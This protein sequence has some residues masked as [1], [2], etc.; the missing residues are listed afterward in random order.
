MKLSTLCYVK[1]DD[2]TLMMNRNRKGD[3][4]EGKW[5]GLGGKF[6]PGESPEECVIREVYEESGLKIS[7]PQ[8][9]GFLT[10]PGFGDDDWYVFVYTANNF[11][12]DLVSGEEGEVRWIKNDDLLNLPLWEGDH[13][14]L[15]WINHPSFFSAKLIYKNN[16]LDDWE[17]HFYTNRNNLESP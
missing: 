11:A 15:E 8:L 1:K 4:H 12:G 10:F 5:N 3:I 17:V 16:V 9:H 13:K 7:D 6:H 2:C 14:F